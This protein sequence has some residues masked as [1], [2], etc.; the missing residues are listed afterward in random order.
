MKLDPQIDSKLF[1]ELKPLN[2]KAEICEKYLKINFDPNIYYFGKSDF[3]D[4]DGYSG[5][6]T[7]M[8]DK[9]TQKPNGFGR[10][11]SNNN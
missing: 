1:N 6:Y 10:I 2:L 8:L 7:G 5:K 9:A 11:I 3:K 4:K